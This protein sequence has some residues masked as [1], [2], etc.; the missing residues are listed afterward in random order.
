MPNK[1]TISELEQVSNIS[2]SDMIVV[3]LSGGGTRKIAVSDLLTSLGIVDLQNQ[4]KNLGY[5]NSV[6][7][8]RRVSVTDANLCVEPGMYYISNTSVL[9]TPDRGYMIVI[10]PYELCTRGIQ[11]L[12]GVNNSAIYF[13]TAWSDDSETFTFGDWITA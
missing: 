3:E 7:I 5:G 13:R 8:G 6:M 4:T 11:V 2:D 12:F 9:N 10:S 1:T